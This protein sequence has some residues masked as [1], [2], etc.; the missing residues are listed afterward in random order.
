MSDTG[1]RKQQTA[2]LFVDPY[3][4]FL[5]E[6]GKFWPR[7]EAVAREVNLLP[8]LKSIVAAVRAAGVRIVV[9]P[10]RRWEPGDYETW[11]HPTQNQLGAA[12]SQAFARGS[13]GGDWH[14]DF[15]PRPGDI[16]AKEH[17]G[18]SGFGNTDLDYLLRQHGI[19]DVIV[20]GLLANTCIEATA[21]FASELGYRVTLVKDA[22]AA[23]SADRMHAA[24]E[25]NGPTYAHIITTTV[26][27]VASLTALAGHG[28]AA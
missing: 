28:E 7:I 22:T 6:G 4:D 25:L 1:Y 14:P 10:H 15:A 21:R 2:L 23:Y 3:N 12:R 9:A 11:A 5:S 26:E 20:V 24:H 13:W 18:S 17:F 8:N 19:V 16:V 27:L